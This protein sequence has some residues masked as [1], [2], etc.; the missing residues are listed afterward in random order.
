MIKDTLSPETEAKDKKDIQGILKFSKVDLE[1]IK[2]QAKKD[3]TLQVLNA[4][5]LNT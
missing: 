5:G 4:L 1:A 3:G 2:I